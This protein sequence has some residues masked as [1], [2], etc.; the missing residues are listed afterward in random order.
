MARVTVVRL[1]LLLPEGLQ[2]SSDLNSVPSELLLRRLMT[3]QNT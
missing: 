1:V 2:A 3:S